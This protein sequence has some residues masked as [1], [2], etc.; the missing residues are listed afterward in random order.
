MRDLEVIDY[1]LRVMGETTL[2]LEKAV[3]SNNIDEAE[4]LKKI[5]AEISNSLS[6]ELV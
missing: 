6:E 4:K 2:K 5:I 1:F 3:N